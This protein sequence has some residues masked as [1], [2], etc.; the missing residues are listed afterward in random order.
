MVDGAYAGAEGDEAAEGQSDHKRRFLG[1][2]RYLLLDSAHDSFD[3][4]DYQH[5]EKK[6][7]KENI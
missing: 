5:S 4:Q 6:E 3:A 7:S 2:E 1:V